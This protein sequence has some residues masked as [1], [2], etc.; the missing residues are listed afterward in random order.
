MHHEMRGVKIR[1]YSAFIRQYYVCL[2]HSHFMCY[3]FRVN[4]LLC[5]DIRK[6]LSS[7]ILSL[8]T[9]QSGLCDWKYDSF[10]PF[11]KRISIVKVV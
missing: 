4:C 8:S 2:I 1:F 9:V 6:L 3:L 7:A 10:N 11:E 5:F